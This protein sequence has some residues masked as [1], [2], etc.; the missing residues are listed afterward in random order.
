M[1]TAPC[2]DNYAYL[3][4]TPPMPPMWPTTNLRVELA[5][6]KPHPYSGSIKPRPLLMHKISI[7]YIIICITFIPELYFPKSRSFRESRPMAT[8][9]SS[10]ARSSPKF[11]SLIKST[12]PKNIGQRLKRRSSNKT[13]LSS[14]A[15][16]S[17]QRGNFMCACRSS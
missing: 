16:T 13:K 5:F 4:Y 14:A 1:D 8:N 3:R 11:K 15:E 17:N 7:I 10:A 9:H 2:P 12:S 6:S